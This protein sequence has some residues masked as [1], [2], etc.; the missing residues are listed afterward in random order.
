M[1]LPS[2]LDANDW[3]KDVEIFKQALAGY[4]ID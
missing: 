2:S 4:K 3:L 1:I